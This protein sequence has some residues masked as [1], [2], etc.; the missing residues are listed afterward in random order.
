MLASWALALA[1]ETHKGLLITWSYRFDTLGMVFRLTLFFVFISL[2]IGQGT[3]DRDTLAPTL[4]GY[5]VWFYAA[6][7]ITMMGRSLMEEAQSGTLE[8]MYL[9]PAPTS[10]IVLGRSLSSLALATPLV[11]VIAASLVV[12]LRI[13]L[14]FRADALPVFLLTIT[15]L[16]GFGFMIGGAT[17]VFKQ[18]AQLSNMA[19]NLIMYLSGVLIPVQNLP[20]WLESLTRLLPTTQGIS[21]IQSV[22]LDGKKLSDTFADGSFGLLVLTASAYLLAGFLV[23]ALCEKIARKQGS[24][25]HY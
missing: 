2:V 9:T 13:D 16:S 14:P 19:E 6:I 10:V 8:Q 20:N 4:L 7:G 18:T 17:I 1:N 24:L 23:F 3:L 25:G 12:L 11:A 15:G 5:V 22:M 21:V